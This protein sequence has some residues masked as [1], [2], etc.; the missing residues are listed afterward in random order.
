MATKSH[1]DSEVPYE[2]HVGETRQYWR[3][4]ILGVNDGL[5]SMVLLVIGVVGAGL[6]RD[7]VIITG[8]A[9]ALAGAVSMGAGEYLATKSQDEVLTSE[10]AL[11]RVHIEHHRD[12]ELDQLRDMF[13][14][15]GI[16][17]DDLDGVV[18]A[19]DRSDAALLNA[20]KALEFGAPDS[21]RRSPYKAMGF[22]AV[23]FFLGATPAVAPF[24]FTDT[25]TQGLWWATVLTAIALF[26]VGVA[27]TRVTKTNPFVAGLENLAIAG[28]G[29]VIA[30]LVGSALGNGPAL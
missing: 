21:E 4:I 24:L 2:P 27:K 18:S 17:D 15:M 11:E 23:L 10:L 12:S 8:I 26:G 5:V 25:A 3:D 30:Y 28:F 13:S 6:S 20:M 16:H 1:R 19:F 14:D 7:D 9:G 29:G 22:S